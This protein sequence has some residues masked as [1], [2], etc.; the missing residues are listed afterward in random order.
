MTK[1][2][3]P[4]TVAEEEAWGRWLAERNYS[5][6]DGGNAATL[7]RGMH[8]ALEATAALRQAAVNP[9]DISFKTYGYEVTLRRGAD[10]EMRWHSARPLHERMPEEQID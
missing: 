4:W 3:E 1:S 2:T 7:W 6:D 9:P 5:Q 10:G 8:R